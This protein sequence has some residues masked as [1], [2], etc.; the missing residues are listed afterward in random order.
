MPKHTSAFLG[1][2]TDKNSAFPGIEE[3]DITIAQD[4]YGYYCQHEWQRINRFTKA[5]IP[6]HLGCANPKCQ[7]GGLALQNLV[8]FYPDGEF[9]LT[10]KG[11]EGTPAG[12]RI[13]D[14]CDNR[15]KVMLAVKRTLGAK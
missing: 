8:L 15:Y 11:H 5:T 7:Q 3:I 10:C 4:P 6:N 9:E 1:T 14:P 2:T 13:G 12:R